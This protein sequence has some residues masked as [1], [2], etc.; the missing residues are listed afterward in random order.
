MFSSCEMRGPNEISNSFQGMRYN[1]RCEKKHSLSE[2]LK[3]FF[4]N[5]KR[6]VPRKFNK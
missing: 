2:D 3:T 1:Y 4:Y 6:N 5:Y